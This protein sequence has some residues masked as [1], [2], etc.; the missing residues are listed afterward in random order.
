MN[1]SPAP[2]V[3][4]TG[5]EIV[6]VSAWQDGVYAAEP[7]APRVTTTMRTP[8][9]NSFSAAARSSAQ[10]VTNSISSSLS[11]TRSAQGRNCRIAA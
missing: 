3:S 1:E 4:V 10:P 5:T 8:R 2:V 11:L 6:A 7:F 9:V